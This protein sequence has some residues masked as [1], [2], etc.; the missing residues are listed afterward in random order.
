MFAETSARHA[1][2][3]RRRPAREEAQQRSASF[4]RVDAPDIQH[5]QRRHA[6]S[7]ERLCVVRSQ[8]ARRGRTD[9]ARRRHRTRAVSLDE[10]L[11]FGRQ[12]HQPGPAW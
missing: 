7:G 10:R 11:L 8:L 12:I 2:A 3:G 4:V 5:V 9:D 1:G 6:G